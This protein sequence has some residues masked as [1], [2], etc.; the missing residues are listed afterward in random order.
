LIGKP[1]RGRERWNV[2]NDLTDKEICTAELVGIAEDWKSWHELKKA[3]SYI[4]L[5]ASEQIIHRE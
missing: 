3:G 2:L 5:H 1:A 4:G